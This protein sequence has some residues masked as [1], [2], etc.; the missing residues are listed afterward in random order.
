[1]ST[2]FPSIP[3]IDSLLSLFF[4]QQLSLKSISQR[5]AVCFGTLIRFMYNPDIR[6]LIDFAVQI[7]D[8]RHSLKANDAIAEALDDL[9]A[10][11]GLPENPTP[12]DKDR[13]R[14]TLDS[15]RRAAESLRKSTTPRSRAQQA[16]TKRDPRIDKP[17]T[18]F[19]TQLPA[20]LEE[21]PVPKRR[22][23]FP[24]GSNDPA[25]MP[26]D[27]RYTLPGGL[28]IDKELWELLDGFRADNRKLMLTM[29]ELFAEHLITPKRLAEMREQANQEIIRRLASGARI[30]DDLPEKLR[31]QLPKVPEGYVPPAKSS[32]E[33]ES[34]RVAA[35]ATAARAAAAAEAA[36]AE[37]A[38]ASAELPNLNSEPS[39]PNAQPSA[40]ASSSSDTS[41]PNAQPSAA[42]NSPSETSSLNPQPS[43]APSSPS[44][45]SDPN[46]Q[47]SA[48]PASSSDSSDLNAQI[49]D[50]SSSRSDTSTLQS[51]ISDE[52]PAQP[53]SPPH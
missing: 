32:Y 6:S 47:T 3:A 33:L 10:L 37:A 24:G 40:A 52:A 7:Q 39:D 49:S 5:M 36:A 27:P 50:P 9:R 14:K 2:A 28:P 21:T 12:A 51:Q 53:P 13:Q 38:R 30:P 1:M 44:G 8:Q 22:I 16:P 42:T 45:T 4:E 17:N 11:R 46:A 48:A 20:E 15:I 31:D 18:I 26:V 25:E 35:A 43:D 29:P 19:T 23:F 34:E 41:A